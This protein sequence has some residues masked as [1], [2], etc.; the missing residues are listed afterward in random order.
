MKRYQL[1]CTNCHSE[2][3]LSVETENNISK[4]SDVLFYRIGM[5]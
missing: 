5:M 4:Q 3:K 2:N 1:K